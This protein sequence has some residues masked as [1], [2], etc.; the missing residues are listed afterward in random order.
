MCS[1]DRAQQ[2]IKAKNPE[3][4]GVFEVFHSKKMVGAEGVEPSTFWSRTK[5]A[6]R[7]RYAPDCAANRRI[8]YPKRGESQSE[9][10]ADAIFRAGGL[11]NRRQT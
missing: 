7:L 2:A 10:G 4:I 6:T 3:N 11:S 9:K 1:R 8:D 5:R